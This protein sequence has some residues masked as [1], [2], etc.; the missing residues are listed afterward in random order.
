VAPIVLAKSSLRRRLPAWIGVLLVLTIG[1][2]GAIAYSAVRRADVEAA[3]TRLRTVADRLAQVARVGTAGRI[4]RMREVAADPAVVASV[5]NPAAREAARRALSILGPDTGATVATLVQDR[6]GRTLV[7]LDRDT[8]ALLAERPDT[9]L[10]SPIVPRGDSLLYEQAVPIRSGGELLGHLVQVRAIRSGQNTVRTVAEL[11]GS[12]ANVFLGN[13]DGSVWTDLERPVPPPP[14]QGKQVRYARDGRTQL[15]TVE[16]I[17]GMP[18]VFGVEFPE[19]LVLAPS[20][21]LL[22]RFAIIGI[23]TIAVGVLLG[24][25]LT[26]RITT[27]L[28]SLTIAAEA[29]AT[30]SDPEPHETSADRGDEIGRLAGAFRAME[31]RVRHAHDTLEQQ[32]ADRTEA[33]KLAQDTLLRNERL[34][35]LG[36]LAS[37]VGH[38]LRNPL[39]VINNAVYYLSATLP[40]SP[41]KARDHLTILANQVKLAEKII[42]DILDFTR[43]KA[44]ELEE[45]SVAQL[46]NEQVARVALT[47]G[48]RIQEELDP[49]LPRIHIDRIQIGQV[50]LNLLTNGVQAMDG[51]GGIL[52]VRASRSGGRVRLEIKDQGP[53]VASENL[54]RIFEPLF[55]TKTRGFGLGLSISRMLVQANGGTLSASNSPE[56]GALFVLELPAALGPDSASLAQ[57]SKG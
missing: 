30:G 53:G 12:G 7:A 57:V 24:W 50:L 37:S 2:Y 13:E 29:I 22:R 19:D 6:E 33:L 27:P 49:D 42:A 31:A 28:T 10:S 9:T 14:A 41:T 45:I 23:A 15:L 34:A 5:R 46:I 11:V 8:K 52:L 21:A 3:W 35:V 48:I 38:E 25:F 17:P 51:V 18:L 26:R 54:D 1:S 32:V 36:Q 39:G 43:I 4:R 56:G 44:P 55:T 47:P 20:R 40:E 16:R